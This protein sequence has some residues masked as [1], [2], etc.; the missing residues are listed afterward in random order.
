MRHEVKWKR[1]KLGNEPS[2]LISTLSGAYTMFFAHLGAPETIKVRK[3]PAPAFDDASEALAY[4][5]MRASQ[6]AM[7]KGNK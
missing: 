6:N 3:E 2:Q 4:W 7:T 1:L 5:Q